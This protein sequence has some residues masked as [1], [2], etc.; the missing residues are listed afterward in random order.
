VLAVTAGCYCWLLLLVVTA[1]CY[2]WLLLLAVTAGCY[3]WLLLLAVTAGCYCLVHDQDFLKLKF[4]AFDISYIF[5][6]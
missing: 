1:G 3:C 6:C 5:F 4:E 2:C